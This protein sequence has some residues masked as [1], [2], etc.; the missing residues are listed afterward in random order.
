M[1]KLLGYGLI[2]FFTV[3]LIVMLVVIYKDYQKNKK[4]IFRSIIAI[5]FNTVFANFGLYVTIVL[6]ALIFGILF[7]FY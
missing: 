1:E 2:A 6:A 4:S 3:N 5:T 7:V